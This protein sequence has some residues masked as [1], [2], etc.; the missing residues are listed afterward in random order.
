MFLFISKKN[1]VF[2]AALFTAGMLLSVFFTVRSRAGLSYGNDP[3]TV[4]VDAGHGLPDGGAVGT[5]G[6]VE[7]E[8]N[9]QIA[10]KIREIL[11]A[12]SIKVIMTRTSEYGIYTD[13]SSTLREMK[14][15]DMR[16][17][18]AIMKKNHADLFISIHMNSYKNPSAS[19]LR[20][21]YSPNFAG[22]KPLAENIQLRIADVTGADT[23]AVMAVE[24][25]LYLLKKPPI[26]SILAECGFLSNPEEEAKLKT[27]DYQS[28]IAWAI[29]DAIEKYYAL[30]GGI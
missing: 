9:L 2:L 22:I 26:P 11:E 28:R 6:T 12:K 20:I 23:G 17:R 13:K 27:E 14:L 15:E 5:N 18:L 8:I 29:A 10:L 24:S 3:I 7:Q 16:N 19:G 4:I 1:L 21:F 25:N 30:Q